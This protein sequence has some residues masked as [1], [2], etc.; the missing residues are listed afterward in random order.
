[1]DLRTAHP[2]LS[3]PVVFGALLRAVGHWVGRGAL[4]NVVA[5][6]LYG[7]LG[8]IGRRLE[9]ML[10]RFAAGCKMRWA[11]RARGSE[12]RGAS[13][14]GGMRVRLWPCGFGWLCRVGAHEAGGIGGYL[15]LVLAHPDMVALLA[16]SP[17]AV[18]LLKPLCRALGIEAL[19]GEVKAAVLKPSR[20]RERP[21]ALE[22]IKLP[23]GVLTAARR[24]GFAK[25]R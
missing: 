3:M 24:Q 21:A 4:D 12:G 1:M 25:R 16:A 20:V 22:R 6:S 15:R 11:V 9:R 19:P 17:Q 18:R 10:A 13:V 14:A 8:E 2:S 5:L 7:R 23:R